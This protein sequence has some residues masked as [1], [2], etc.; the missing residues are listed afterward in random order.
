MIRGRFLL[1]IL[2]LLMLSLLWNFYVEVVAYDPFEGIEETGRDGDDLGGSSGALKYA[3]GREIEDKNLFSKSRKAET[4]APQPVV[5]AEPEPPPKERPRLRLNGIIRDQFGE[6]VAYIQRGN[7][8]LP[9]LRKGD[10]V[11][12]LLVVDVKDRDVVLSWEGEEIK[13]SMAKVKTLKF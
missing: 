6:H 11:D 13:L 4:P 8:V 10:R 1:G 9:P 2:L 5:E 3:W 7:S 12:D